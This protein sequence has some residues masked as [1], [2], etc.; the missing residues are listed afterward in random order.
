VNNSIDSI[1][2]LSLESLNN[3]D[4]IVRAFQ[5]LRQSAERLSSVVDGIGLQR[6]LQLPA[7]GKTSG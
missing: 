1:M 3:T 4:S 7:S 5:H 6:R 2:N